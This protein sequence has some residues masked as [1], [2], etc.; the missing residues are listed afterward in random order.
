MALSAQPLQ[1]GRPFRVGEIGQCPQLLVDG[2]SVASQ[3]DVKTRHADGSVRFAVV[4]A[5]LPAVP[6]SGG[7]TLSFADGPCN[8][9]GALSAQQML[10]AE[11][12]FD[13]V[14]SLN[15]GAAGT[16][17]AR[18][19]IAAGKYRLWTSGPVV[20]TAIVADHEGKSADIGVDGYK[21]VRP[22]FE[23]QFWPALKLTRTRVVME[24]T[25]TEK[26]QNQR[27]GVTITAGASSPQPVY[28]R[29]DVEH[30]YM[31]R[32]TRTFWRGGEPAALNIDYNVAYLAATQAI[33]NYDASIR[34]SSTSKSSIVSAWQAAPKDIFEQ[35]MWN[36]SM[37]TTGGRPDLGPYPKWMVAWLYDGSAELKEVALG[38]ADLAGAWP[39]HLREGSAGKYVDRD[40]TEP[41]LG[42]PVSGYAR[43]TLAMLDLGYAYSDAAD[44]VKVVGTTNR[45][46][47]VPDNAH[48]PQPFFIPY[49]LTGEHFYKEQ[50]QFWSGFS[51]LDDSR[52][53]Y[54]LYCY[55]K[56]ASKSHLG[57]GG[58][59]RGIAWGMRMLG[60]AAWAVPQQEAGY[61]N[62][63]HAAYED[64]ITRFEGTRG[65]VRGGN[66][67]RADWQWANTAGDCHGG[68][69]RDANPLRYW[70]EGLDGYGSNE[71]VKRYDAPWQHSF[72]MY[73]LS[74]G[75]ELGLPAG[76]L[77]DWFAPFFVRQVLDAGAV[78]YHLGDY[79]LPFVDAQTGALYQRWSDVAAEY[80][81]YTGASKWPPAASPNSNS[82]SSLDQGYGTAAL[83]ALAGTAGAPGSA[84]AW[85]R[86]GAGHYAAWGWERDPKWAIL[87]RGIANVATKQGETTISTSSGSTTASAGTSTG[88]SSS[89]GTGTSTSSTT[90]TSPSA[91]TEG[92]TST[93]TVTPLPAGSLPSW[94]A[95][96]PLFQWFQI[97]G[98]KLSASTAW[99]GYTPSRGGQKGIL[100]Y[101]GGTLKASGSE[102]FIAGGGHADYAGNEVFSIALRSETPIWV[103]RNNPSAAP[104]LPETGTSHYPD[105]RPSSR[106][107]YWTLQ[108][109]DSRNLLMFVGAP[110]LWSKVANG[111]SEFDAFDPAKNDYLPAGTFPSQGG[112]GGVAQGIAK[113][114]ADNIYVHSTGGTM[115]RWDNATNTWTTLGN[116]GTYYYETPYAIDTRRNRMIRMPNGTL[117]GAVFDLN[118]NAAASTLTLT[119]S[120][121]AAAN[122]RGSLVYDPVSDAFWYWKRGDSTLYRIDAATF[123]T[124][125]QSVTGTVP[126]NTVLNGFYYTYGRFAYVPELRGILYMRDADSD[127]FF[128]RTAS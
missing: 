27:Y 79:T 71:S 73:A 66:T 128:V 109:N 104:V 4:S 43:P 5:V 65:V 10:G 53:L 127:I 37:P 39:M 97:P 92:T 68:R 35:G 64:V 41:A 47:W 1:F 33:P 67:S 7:V 86:F 125:A 81:D 106:H 54:G 52:G 25:D 48:Q 82:T 91:S 26:V 45:G 101:S 98:T 60:E 77:K 38:Q 15:D 22:S 18:A 103:R 19:L 40:K 112:I 95:A 23:V 11:Y 85:S 100:A 51:L 31:S 87:P 84:E 36:P 58:Q 89:S 12:D 14:V 56:N 116:R 24:T 83:V 102:L 119:G 123:N 80:A 21:S 44:K 20:T 6:A 94:V 90:S 55:S 110:A 74:R 105:G 72:L 107:T 124:T 69:L 63:L 8:N 30:L 113:D 61:R 88:T 9:D 111:T 122:G 121:A 29:A 108:F 78:P 34:L 120:A 76:A 3:S 75:A 50:L 93:V 57:I 42:Q 32:W 49:L 2:Q 118:N 17:S 46:A 70:W 99:Q 13:A 117:A 16:A 126:P 115:Y 59:I 62:Y 114:A 96:K 28:S